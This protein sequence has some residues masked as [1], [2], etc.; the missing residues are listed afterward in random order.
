VA[1]RLQTFTALS[2]NTGFDRNQLSSKTGRRKRFCRA[3]ISTRLTK[4]I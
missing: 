4:K 3:M 1:W 2:L